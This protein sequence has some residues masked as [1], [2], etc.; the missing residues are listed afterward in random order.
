[1]IPLPSEEQEAFLT[2]IETDHVLGDCVAGSGKTTT[3]LLIAQRYPASRILQVTYNAQLKTEVR[4][5][6]VEAGLTNLEIHTFHSLAVAYYAG[7]GY[8]DNMI[9]AVLDKAAPLRTTIRPVDILVLDETQDM[10]PTYFQLVRKF[11]GDLRKAPRLVVLG[12]RYQGIYGFKGADTR[13]LT[14]APDLWDW[15]AFAPLTLSTSYRVSQHIATFV[16]RNMLGYE[17]LRAVHEGPPVEYVVCNPFAVHRWLANKIAGL[18]D[19]GTSGSSSSSG[20][21]AEDIFVLVSSLKNPSAPVR[22]LENCLV[23]MG[24][25]CYF[26]TSDDR[27]A[28]EDILGGKVVFSTFHQAKGRERKVVIVYGF[29][30]SYERNMEAEKVGSCPEALYVAATRAKERLILLQAQAKGPLSFLHSL[31]AAPHLHLVQLQSGGKEVQQETITRVGVM[32]TDEIHTDTVTNIT[33]FLGEAALYHLSAL[34]A[35]LFVEEAAESYT[36]P[37]CGK[38]AS[39]TGW[40]DVADINGLVIPAI[41]EARHCSPEHHMATIEVDVRRAYDDFRSNGT[42]GFLRAACDVLPADLVSVED[43][44]RLGVLYN[45]IMER[46][47]NRIQQIDRYDWLTEGDVAACCGVLKPHLHA[48]TIFEQSVETDCRT[49]EFGRIT[50][51]GRLDA[52]ND[53]TIWEI[54]CVETLTVEHFTQVVLYA[55][56]W[57]R[58][59][60][61]EYGARA[62]RLVNLRTGQILRLRLDVPHL[63]EEAVHVVFANKWAKKPV[64]TDAEFL[65]VAKDVVP[66]SRTS[67]TKMPR[68]GTCMIGDD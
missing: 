49:A 1:M 57:G 25:P 46:V 38:V 68:T 59:Y 31:H 14:L 10:V 42:Q 65:A 50:L 3:V 56:M 47:Y 67:S 37:I 63:L 54:K 7:R 45:S 12:D 13:F 5:K 44:L 43:Y 53:D 27:L 18:L 41:Y 30:A 17:R 21:V 19:T 20:Y 16:N 58:D 64:L 51:A 62:F 60:V 40:E 66:A 24:I 23:E 6:A 26:P 52:V 29:D 34:T 61:E 4:A 48:E 39:A 15:S 11:V 32:E 35:E 28:D 8:D 9:K 33:R 2:A 22:K 36:V 55:W